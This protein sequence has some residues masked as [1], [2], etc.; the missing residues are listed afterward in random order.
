MIVPKQITHFFKNYRETYCVFP[1]TREA[2]LKTW[3]HLTLL[4]EL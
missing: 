2:A 3:N 1:E 4:A